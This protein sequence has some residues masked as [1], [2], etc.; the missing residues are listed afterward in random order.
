MTTREPDDS[1]HE[2][3]P[4]PEGSGVPDEDS[5]IGRWTASVR[6]LPGRV[7]DEWR[8]FVADW[9]AS[10][11]EGRDA[12]RARRRR[13]PRNVPRSVPYMAGAATVVAGREDDANSVI[14]RIE[15]ASEVEVLLVVPRRARG[16]R[17]AMAWPRI[18]A[19]ARQRGLTVRVLAS[20][21]DVREHALNAGLSTARTTGGL[22]PAP[23]VSIPLGPRELTLRVPSVTP[24][25]RLA[26]FAAI[27]IVIFGAAAYY[28]PSAD[29]YIAPPGEELTS[30]AR[31]HLNPVG[32]TDI[33]EGVVGATSVSETIVA[34]ASTVTTGT[35][36]VGDVAAKV[37]LEFTNTSEAD[38]RLPIG[39]AVEDAGEF[40]FTTD[41][42]ATVAAGEVAYVP[43]TAIRPGT[44]GNVEAGTVRFLIGF[45]TTLT[46]TNPLAAAGGEDIEVPAAAAEDAV[47][48]GE[49]A[50]DV[51]RRAGTRALERLV[52]DGTVF[53][54]TVS[55]AILSQE[56]LVEPG[57]PAE[58]FLMEYT[59]L[60]SAI[61][62]PDDA[63]R[64]AGEQILVSVLPDG[65]ALIPGTADAV[66]ENPIFDGSRLVA[67]LNATG[68][69]TPL[70]DPAS[71]RGILTGVAPSAAAT[72][73]REELSLDV[74]PLIRVHPGFLPAVR[75]P[76]R[77]DRIS[78]VFLSK[79]DLAAEIAGLPEDDEDGAGEDGADDGAGDE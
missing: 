30:A 58:A 34:V 53:P 1:T 26:A 5:R 77:E 55:V 28:V 45:P 54:E 15:T 50:E 12:P 48:V 57:D 23:A 63:A 69:A 10:R 8:L 62:L 47:R 73:L 71:L 42:A 75:M 65:M 60:V 24:L 9:R 6:G 27:P 11:A 43:A 67:T 7:R 79:E 22:R 74:E 35:A 56:P 41:E 66:A 36:S 46:V 33:G 76:R 68:L 19:H 16:L 49:I 70:F 61:V 2:A 31:V 38:V 51:L 78:I 44:V 4:P 25:I 18:A 59:A 72:R 37:E 64:R 52:E 17:D 32:E 20:R 40:T 14:G 3:E 21:R 39:T 13:R 29:I